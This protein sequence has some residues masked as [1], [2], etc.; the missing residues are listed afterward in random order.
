MTLP[1]LKNLGDFGIAAVELDHTF[2]DFE[3]LAGELERLEFETEKGLERSIKVLGRFSECG[4]RIGT[5]IEKMAKALE[6]ARKSAEI[7]VQK[8]AARAAEIQAR[9]EEYER[10]H[11]RFKTLSETVRKVSSTMSDLQSTKTSAALSDDEKH[12]IA[13]RL[14]EFEANLGVL[15]DESRKLEES[16]KSVNLK[17]LVE[18]AD[19]MAQSLGAAKRRLSNF[20]ESRPTLQ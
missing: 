2:G 7:A 14:P 8:T 12:A 5:N 1:S 17:S 20:I 19:A 16:A 10:L 13:S 11:E 15:I 3:R 6:G 4:V 9:R 18:N